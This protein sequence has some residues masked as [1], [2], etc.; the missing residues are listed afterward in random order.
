MRPSSHFVRV[1]L[2]AWLALP[3][4]ACIELPPPDP[5]PDPVPDAGPVGPDERRG[6]GGAV[7]LDVP[8]DPSQ[9]G[10]SEVG[11]RTVQVALP[12]GKGDIPMEVWY[13]AAP[14]SE[15]G[16]EHPVY[17][18][19]DFLPAGEGA[20][21]PD[22]EATSD[23]LVSEAYRDVPIDA[24]HGPYPVVVMIHGTASFR[25]ASNATMIHWASRGFVVVAADH[26]G[27]Y[28]GD[29]LALASL[30]SCDGRG[31]GQNVGRDLDAML[32][33]LDAADGALAFLD[34]HVDMT[35]VGLGGHSQGAGYAANYTDRPGVRVSMMMAGGNAS[36]SSDTLEST[37]AIGGIDDDIVSWNMQKLAYGN[38]P[39]PKRLIG[40]T[41][42]GHLVFTDLCG[43]TNAD[44]L[45]AME[46]AQKYE[47]CGIWAADL[48]WDC[49]DDHI[50]QALQTEMVNYTT[51]A[52][53]EETLQ[54]A[55]RDAAFAEL[56]A[57]YANVGEFEE[58]L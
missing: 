14:G 22:E 44:G 13:P 26:P 58:D 28:L 16:A 54:C 42:A 10:P 15:V 12:S 38:S 20:R 21:I 18:L 39:S 46:V 52:V 50:P 17:D 55:D 8:A 3:S 49:D 47:V 5:D 36:E 57:R 40:F 19:R 7:F 9:R 6:C 24:E 56:A 34:G 2:A 41:G 31:I 25:V 51:A 11:V 48:A 43:G 27:M 23:A 1:A 35:R 4:S 45:D 32:A 37:L 29:M 53:L 30:G 33:A